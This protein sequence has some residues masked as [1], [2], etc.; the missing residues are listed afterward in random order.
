MMQIVHRILFRAQLISSY[1]HAY[2]LDFITILAYLRPYNRE[3]P[4]SPDYRSPHRPE[5]YKPSPP[6]RPSSSSSKGHRSG[7]KGRTEMSPIS[8]RA[9]DEGPAAEYYRRYKSPRARSRT[10]DEL[11]MRDLNQTSVPYDSTVHTQQSKS[12]HIPPPNAI[13]T[14]HRSPYHPPQQVPT[15]QYSNQSQH[16]TQYPGQSHP[17]TQQ[18]VGQSQPPAQSYNGQPQQPMQYGGQP[19]YIP[20]PQYQ[21]PLQQTLPAQ[22]AH[23]QP[24]VYQTPA[25]M[26]SYPAQMVMPSV[27]MQQ[28]VASEY[29]DKHINLFS[30]Y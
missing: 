10:M 30:G 23:I 7:H 27:P 3:D 14:P 9:Y 24:P 21:P 5:E 25:A 6:H 4:Q 18:Y 19:T 15:P 26:T 8:E 12:G 17:P 20:Q 22:P 29:I 11:D 2:S 1:L 28:Q 16:P 13:S